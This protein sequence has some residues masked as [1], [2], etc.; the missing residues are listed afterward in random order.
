[1]SDRQKRVSLTQEVIKILRNTKKE[2]PSSVKNNLLLEFSFRIKFYGFS[3]KFRLEVISSIMG[4]S[5]VYGRRN[6]WPGLK[7]LYAHK[8]DLMAT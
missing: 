4:Q 7:L 3:E 8:T 1:M 2:L 5:A 6:N